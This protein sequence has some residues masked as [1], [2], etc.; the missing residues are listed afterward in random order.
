ML[1]C[2]HIICECKVEWLK[3]RSYDVQSQKYLL[4]DLLQRTI[5][6]SSSIDPQ[7]PSHYIQI[8]LP[9]SYFH[10]DV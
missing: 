5:A 3:Q 4:F 2:L 8:V 9:A 7:S 6:R 10:I 1:I